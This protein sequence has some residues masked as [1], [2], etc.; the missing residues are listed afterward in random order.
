MHPCRVS[1]WFFS[2]YR[3]KSLKHE[4]LCKIRAGT[5]RVIVV[6]YGHPGVIYA[7]QGFSHQGSGKDSAHNQ[8]GH[9]TFVGGRPGGDLFFGDSLRASEA[10]EDSLGVAS[11][12]KAS[13]WASI[14]SRFINATS[15]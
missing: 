7:N 4:Y 13:I 9:Q 10:L 12:I 3:Y 2:T 14:A 5:R 11:F 6:A 1:V 8:D 15:P